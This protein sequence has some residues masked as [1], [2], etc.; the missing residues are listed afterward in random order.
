MINYCNIL[1][2]YIAIFFFIAI[3]DLPIHILGALISISYYDG[4]RQRGRTRELISGANVR[5]VSLFLTM[6]LAANIFKT[7]PPNAIYS[8]S[9]L[10]FPVGRTFV[11]VS[12][13]FGSVHQLV[14]YC[15]YLLINHIALSELY[16]Y[17]YSKLNQNRY[18]SHDHYT[19]ACAASNIY[20]WHMTYVC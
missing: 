7:S 6:C 8:P 11:Q 3:I 17:L 16:V 5:Y 9:D 13:H 14:T 20:T 12:T 15:D 1:D 2:Q 10:S 4:C 19:T 18:R